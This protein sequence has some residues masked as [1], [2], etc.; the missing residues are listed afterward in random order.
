[1]SS[2]HDGLNPSSSSD[3]RI[4]ASASCTQERVEPDATLVSS[5]EQSEE[6]AHPRTVELGTSTS[7][8]QDSKISSARKRAHAEM[9][10]PA[11]VSVHCSAPK[12][13]RLASQAATVRLAM[14]AEGAVKVRRSD[15]ETPSPPKERAPAADMASQRISDRTSGLQRS[16]SAVGAAEMGAPPSRPLLAIP[17][18]VEGKLGRSRDARTWEFYC[19]NEARDIL[20]SHAENERNGSAVGAINLI[21]SQSQ[22]QLREMLAPVASRSNT[23]APA[24]LRSNGQ[25]SKPKLAR[26]KS[27]LARLQGTELDFSK[28]NGKTSR[29]QA[30][31]S[32]SGDSDK[33]NWAPG[34]HASQNPLRR[35]HVTSNDRPILTDNDS[36]LSCAS[37][38]NDNSENDN[39]RRYGKENKQPLPTAPKEK[40][41]D[42]DCVAS[43]LSLSQGAW[44]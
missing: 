12:P 5:F 14:T 23:Q 19:D 16:K 22:R 9:A 13:P 38:V 27:S 28:G 3:N 2:I 11:S 17:K 41:T 4:F 42:L 34:T 39:K 8:E 40:G 29:P 25:R 31:R 37:S 21:R 6:H 10:S 1:M 26:A 35:L 30:A 43:L 32:P 44:R 20:S 7:S 15:E 24:P 33:E 36:M 18:G